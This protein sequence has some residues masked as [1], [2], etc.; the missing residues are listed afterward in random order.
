M[1]RGVVWI[2]RVWFRGRGGVGEGWAGWG[3]GLAS[4]VQN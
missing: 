1:G 2:E 3:E 4:V